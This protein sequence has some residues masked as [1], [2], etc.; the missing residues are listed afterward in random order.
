M[1][2]K[3]FLL[4][5]ATHG[6]LGDK[7][8]IVNDGES[9]EDPFLGTYLLPAAHWDVDQT[10]VDNLIP[11]KAEDPCPMYYGVDGKLC[12]RRRSVTMS[13]IPS[14][15]TDPCEEGYFGFLTYY[16]SS[17][18]VVL[19]HSSLVTAQ[20]TSDGS[21]KVEFS[22][23]EAFAKA[24]ATW[25]VDG[26]LILAVNG[27]GCATSKN[28]RCYYNCQGL[29][30]DETNQVIVA[31][32]WAQDPES[33]AVQGEAE[34][35]YWKP[36]ADNPFCS[37]E[38]SAPGE[39]SGQTGGSGSTDGS[40]SGLGGSDTG[41]GNP[42]PNPTAPSVPEESNIFGVRPRCRAPVDT[43][44][45]LPTACLGEYFDVDLDDQQGS[46]RRQLKSCLRSLPSRA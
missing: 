23:S 27:E 32:G 43:T 15:L 28:D 12:S 34:W 26:G 44:Y 22:S 7:R 38:G 30:I 10:Y 9:E 6:V 11:I 5:V 37:P 46:I 16:F 41:S 3:F 8:C 4:V 42:T 39:G 29:M 1:L 35:G 25:S 20:Y 18:V 40:D 21:L 17:P 36:R 24:S 14:L 2:Y 45:G 31:S 19:D 33:L 13:L